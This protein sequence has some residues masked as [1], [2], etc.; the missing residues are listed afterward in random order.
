MGFFN[1]TVSVNVFKNNIIGCVFQ[2]ILNDI[3]Y[4]IIIEK[5]FLD[6]NHVLSY[7]EVSDGSSFD[8]TFQKL[9]PLNS[10]LQDLLNDIKLLYF[11]IAQKFVVSVTFTCLGDRRKVGMENEKVYA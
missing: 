5:R 10:I 6:V 11:S 7:F 9:L 3:Q 1:G 4:V 2:D 8:S